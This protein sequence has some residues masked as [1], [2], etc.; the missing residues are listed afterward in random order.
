VDGVEVGQPVG[1]IFHV[2]SMDDGSFVALAHRNGAPLLL[3][4]R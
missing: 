3:C 4:A 1:G 2:A